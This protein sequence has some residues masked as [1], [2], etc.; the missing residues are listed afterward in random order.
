M[1]R[2]QGPSEGLRVM[3]LIPVRLLGIWVAL[4]D[5]ELNLSPKFMGHR[6]NIHSKFKSYQNESARIQVVRY[7]VACL[8]QLGNCEITCG[9]TPVG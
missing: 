8:K 6:L 3:V 2:K 1:E 9:V 5:S 4:A 7:K